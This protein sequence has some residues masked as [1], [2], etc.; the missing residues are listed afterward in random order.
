MKN[1]YKLYQIIALIFAICSVT[2][3]L[4]AQQQRT[5]R[6][7]G[8]LRQEQQ[9]PTTPFTPPQR[10]P[11][12]YK[13]VITSKAKTEKGL[14]MVHKLDDKYYFEIA[15][16]LIKREFI[17][18]TRYTRTPAGGGYGGEI[19]NQN[20]LYFEKGPEN[21]VL[22]RSSIIVN[23]AADPSQPLAQAVRNSNEDPIVAVFDIKALGKDSTGVVID[24]TDFFKS[25]NA[26]ISM[27]NSTKTKLK[28]TMP[29]ADRIFLKSIHAYPINTEVKISKT[30]GIN[31]A[32]SMPI[33][34]SAGPGLPASNVG[35]ATFEFNISMLLLPKEPMKRR[36]FDARVG[37][38]SDD[39][40]TYDE[41]KQ[42]SEKETF[43]VRWRLEPKPGDV[44]KMKHGELVEPIKP[45]VFYIDPAT[46]KKWRKF[47]I[48]GIEDWSVTFEQ[49]GFKNAIH[50]YEWPEKDSTMSLEDARFSVIRYYASD[51]E[52]ASGPNVHDPRSGEILESHVNLYN[53]VIKRLYK[54][55]LIQTAA[56]DINARN[57]EYSEALMGRLM[58]YVIC[59]EVGHTLGLR[60]NFASS[61]AIPV[62]KLRDKEF[63]KKYGQSASIMD[64]AR[65]NYVAQPEDGIT[66]LIPII[67]V[68]DKWAIEWGYKP[69]FTTK[70]AKEEKGELNK[71]V[72][73]H[74]KDPMYLFGS[75]ASLYDPRFQSE[76][77]G[78]NAMKAGEYGIRNL[79][80]ILPHLIE[81]TREEG[82]TYED[83][84]TMYGELTSQFSRYM[85][86]AVK[87]IGGVYE[88][89]KTYDMPGAQ[90][91][92]VPR[93]LQKDA[94]NFLSK[95]IFQ[96]PYWLLDKNILNKISHTGGMEM[97]TP[98]QENVLNAI[99][100]ARKLNILAENYG[101][102][103]QN[104][105]VDELF[106]DLKKGIW[107]ELITKK[108][109]DFCRRNL[110]KVYVDKLIA[111]IDEKPASTTPETGISVSRTMGANTILS[112]SD[113][114]SIVKR[115]LKTL[116]VEMKS[117]SVV[118]ADRNTK[119]HWVDLA[120]RIDN[121]FNKK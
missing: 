11:K 52:N 36:A 55:Y 6:P 106:F 111:M 82:E 29:I 116:M 60:H 5:E 61:W 53:D 2:F 89:P 30:Y 103:S 117:A 9:N 24:V 85:G 93:K 33:Q 14:F 18:V 70:N 13:E 100:Q 72:L 41:N 108:P 78:D 102:N 101:S 28:L 1:N 50:A 20:V 120:E 76:D 59:H 73:S 113:V 105:S 56:I 8:I 109:V 22:L 47:L 74:V 34:G 81:W 62:E 10:T 96:T 91:E 97:I 7:A 32:P 23:I 65:F 110:Q 67:S 27:D 79:K 115:H 87:N 112:K 57:K 75:E 4:K 86:H 17:A 114:Y 69:V 25:E 44:D 71:W 46:P 40:T 39:F 31:S 98:I 84:S 64:Y 38:F 15:D 12:P 68:Y 58:Q 104:Y 49:A 107:G 90:F 118:Q 16:S 94:I 77:L 63:V 92:A 45:I 3:T 48:K 26:V 35:A 88:T 80:R 51:V 19:V 54:W 99:L 95:N 42:G 37:F 21:K 119:L 121:F 66:D 43:A 83:L